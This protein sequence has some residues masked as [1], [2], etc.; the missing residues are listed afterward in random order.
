MSNSITFK[1]STG[2]ITADGSNTILS[3]SAFAGNNSR[4]PQ[5]PTKIQG[6]NNPNMCSLHFIGP[7]PLG[8]YSIGPFTSHPE[9]GE[10]SAQ[11]TQISGESYGRS[12]FFIHGPGSV[13]PLNS[14]EGCI[15]VPH[16][17]RLRISELK[18]E[19]LN[20]IK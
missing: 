19:K 4:M 18:P 1:I 6:M 2:T 8:E 13:D 20:V 5:N 16:F 12:D 10:N 11:L 3:T 14:S 9:V 7:L 17:D 15:V